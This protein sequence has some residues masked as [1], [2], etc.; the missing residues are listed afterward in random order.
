[1]T[2]MIR[3]ARHAALAS[4]TTLLAL[5]VTLS[6]APAFAKSKRG[7]SAASSTPARKKS[8]A[9]GQI[10]GRKAGEVRGWL[11]DVLQK[12]FELTDAED[13]KGK[14]NK[15]YAKI[16]SDLGVEAVVVG[17]VERS[18]LVLSVRDG[19]DGSEVSKI[20]LHAPA[21]PKLKALIDK[22]L[23]KKLFA[24]FGMESPS[25]TAQKSA[26]SSE[27]EEEEAAEEQGEAEAE[28]ESSDGEEEADGESDEGD[29]GDEKSEATADAA[30]SSTS[31]FPLELSLGFDFS[32]RSFQFKDTLSQLAPQRPLALPLRD[33]NSGLDATIVL[34]GELYPGAFGGD[35]FLANVGLLG[36][37]GY[38]IP[39][40]IV[41][42]PA[43]GSQKELK[44]SVQDWFLGLRLRVP[45]GAKA[46]LGFSW[47]YGAQK[48]YLKGDE[49]G[50]LV[51]DVIYTYTEPALDLR[52]ALGR[53]F[54]QAQLGARL[55]LDS[56]EL[57]NERLWFKSVGGRG[58]DGSLK[59]GFNV[60][61]SVFVFAGGRM[62]RYGF[63][64]NPVP[65]DALRVAGGATDQFIGGILGVGYRLPGKAAAVSAASE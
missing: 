50:P 20:E 65:A 55:V 8:I 43:G 59:L 16:A 38:G 47:V 63:D 17:K 27:E 53:V 11:R 34:R 58:V 22:R 4:L 19:A 32:K 36:G 28:A 15:S 49:T 42:K 52:V 12:N 21:G 46:Q 48:Y 10:D 2:T 37:F 51:P 18:R 9:L 7:S 5:S 31:A 61:P 6:P 39:S 56:G 13:F 3:S 35:G 30:S 57:E 45:L 40:K 60:T 25:D 29:E 33:Y 26:E 24:A 54:V 64:F 23:A 44:N 14:N 41:Y 62:V 1:M